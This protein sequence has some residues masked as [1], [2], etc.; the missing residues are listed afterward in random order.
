MPE[1]ASCSSSPA[2]LSATSRQP[3]LMGWGEGVF[4]RIQEPLRRIFIWWPVTS[5]AHW[6]YI[7]PRQNNCHPCPSGAHSP[8][9]APICTSLSDVCR[10]LHRGEI[11]SFHWAIYI[12]PT[13]IWMKLVLILQFLKLLFPIYEPQRNGD[14]EH[15]V[16][17]RPNLIRSPFSVSFWANHFTWDSV[18]EYARFN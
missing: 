3:C 17:S 2:S 1:N 7:C 15:S 8:M 13:A 5:A 6:L 14:R 9:R 4:N 16:A 11:R 10:G 12:N 18:S